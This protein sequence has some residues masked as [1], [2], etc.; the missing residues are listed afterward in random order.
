MN[1]TRVF[2]TEDEVKRVKEVAAL[3]MIMIG[4]TLPEDPRKLVHRLA[5]AHGLPEISGYYGADLRTGEIVIA[6]WTR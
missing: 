2:L 4:G 6:H 1:Y 3:P 5:L